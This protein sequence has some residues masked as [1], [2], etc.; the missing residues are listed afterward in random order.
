MTI[1]NPQASKKSVTVV[2]ISFLFGVVFCLVL[3]KGGGLV[4]SV[5]SLHK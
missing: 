5:G 4:S 3:G 1:K 2:S